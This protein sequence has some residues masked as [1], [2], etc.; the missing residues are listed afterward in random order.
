M[1][2]NFVKKALIAFSFIATSFVSAQEYGVELNYG[3]NGVFEPSINEI[4]HFGGGF[5]YNFD[6]TYGAKIDFGSDKYRVNNELFGKETGV[7]S[8]RVSLQG[9]ANVSTIFSRASSY[10]FFNLIA[11]A[12]AGYTRISS[13][14]G[15]KADNVV[16]IIGG[17]TPRFRVTDNF[18]LTLDTSVIFNISQHYNFDGSLSYTDTVNSFTG[19]TYNVSAGIVYK[20]S[21]F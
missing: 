1:K 2:F 7:N 19:I 17:L 10:D 9:T 13:T 16:N 20:I 11:H 3:L 14:E 18:F 8:T 5:F 21:S 15:G 12:G 6:E 4:S